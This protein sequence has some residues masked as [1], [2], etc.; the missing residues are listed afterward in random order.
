MG[1][2][3]GVTGCAGAANPFTASHLSTPRLQT[4]LDTM[5]YGSIGIWQHCHADFQSSGYAWSTR[6]QR[7][8]PLISPDSRVL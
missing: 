3:R 6:Q 5:A 1:H 4:H 2:C 7:T 8:A